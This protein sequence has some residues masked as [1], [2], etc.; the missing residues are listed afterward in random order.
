MTNLEL[1]EYSLKNP[2]PLIDEAYVKSENIILAKYGKKPNKLMVTNIELL[3]NI[4]AYKVALKSG[5]SKALREAIDNIR[6][7]L[8]TTGINYSEFPSF[9][10]VTD[11]SHSSY[12]KLSE[13]EQIEFLENVLKKYIK[14]RHPIYSGYG[15]THSTLQVGKDAKAHKQSGV[16][17]I[18]KVCSI[19]NKKRF[20]ALGDLSLKNLKAKN[21]VY[22]STDKT[23]KKLFKEIIKQYSISF[24]WGKKSDDK[25]PDILFKIK[26]HFFIVEHKHMKEGGGGQ[27]KQINEVIKFISY[28]EPRSSKRIHYITFLDGL[29]FNLLNRTFKKKSKVPTQVANIKKA[30]RQNENNY[31]VNTAGFKELLEQVI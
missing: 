26:N 24:M 17:G 23:G 22:I 31:F 28:S 13:S 5:N 3:E 15:Y 9:W 6:V 30:L 25:M 7:C 11:V 1:F 10:A 18:K 16:L 8:K 4:V 27:N 20:H 12:K 14:H 29:Y 21:L 19:L 2:E